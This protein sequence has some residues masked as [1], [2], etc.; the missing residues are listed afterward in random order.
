LSRRRLPALLLNG[1]WKNKKK[2]ER[3]EI[4]A[5]HASG[6]RKGEMHNETRWSVMDLI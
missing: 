3:L 4:K 5:E 1:Q 2:Q 6:Q